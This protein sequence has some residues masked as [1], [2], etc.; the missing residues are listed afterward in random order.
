MKVYSQSL[1][2]VFESQSRG[3]VL[4]L[5]VFIGQTVLLLGFGES[6]PAI[7]PSDT[8]LPL[9]HP[10]SGK[11]GAW[12]GLPSSFDAPRIDGA[13]VLGTAHALSVIIPSD[14]ILPLPHPGTGKNGAS[15]GLPSLFL[16]P[17]I[18]GASVLDALHT[19]TAQYCTNKTWNKR[20][21]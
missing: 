4:K 2:K 13:S 11:N 20:W 10:G 21:Y 19:V 9:P 16:A 1:W 15:V 17:R 14:T 18:D 8:R 3:S 12:V 5:G 6:L 7:I